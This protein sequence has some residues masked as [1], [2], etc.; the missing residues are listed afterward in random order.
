MVTCMGRPGYLRQSPREMEASSTQGDSLHSC[1]MVPMF[2]ARFSR[3]PMS[4]LK[5]EN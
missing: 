1:W 3:K 2:T 5:E 4:V